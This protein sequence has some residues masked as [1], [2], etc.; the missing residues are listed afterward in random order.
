MQFLYDE[1]Y[2][3]LMKETKDLFFMF[4]SGMTM[5]SVLVFPNHVSVYYILFQHLSKLFCGS[6]K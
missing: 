4:M 2:K 6:L 3:T 1:N 5:L